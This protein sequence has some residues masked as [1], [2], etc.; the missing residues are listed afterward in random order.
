MINELLKVLTYILIVFG[1][2]IVISLLG[3]GTLLTLEL[4][5]EKWKERKKSKLI[6]GTSL[7][8]K[9]TNNDKGLQRRI[10]LE[11]ERKKK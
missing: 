8:P 5:K 11:K 9:F 2:A 7:P 4:I 10:D 3:V 1:G 6:I